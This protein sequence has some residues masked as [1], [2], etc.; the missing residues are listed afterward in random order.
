MTLQNVMLDLH[1]QLAAVQS[2]ADLA[3]IMGLALTGS[4]ACERLI[5]LRRDRTSKHF[6]SVAEIGDVPAELH[7]EAPAIAAR[8]APFLPHVPL[9]A[10]LQPPFADAAAAPV[11]RL[12][13]LGFVRAVWLNVEKQVD[14]LV[15]VGP[16]L[17]A[18]EYD[19]LH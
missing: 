13:A 17:S 9:L 15:I 18:E 10:P 5:V 6:E 3:R 1:R 4:F 12:A 19:P 11:Q 16:Q 8:I 7:E 14:W 2:Q